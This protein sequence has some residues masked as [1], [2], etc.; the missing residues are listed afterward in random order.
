MHA[1]VLSA[2]T[3]A[4]VPPDE[5]N[6]MPARVTLASILDIA[7]TSGPLKATLPLR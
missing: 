1:R 4:R 5:R 7:L 6:C 2:G 3:I